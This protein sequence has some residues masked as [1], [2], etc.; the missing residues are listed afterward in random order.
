MKTTISGRA[1]KNLIEYPCLMVDKQDKDLIILAAETQ[2][3]HIRTT[4]LSG[5]IGESFLYTKEEI[6]EIFEVFTGKITIEND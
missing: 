3:L 6:E 1:N 4:T 2:G 5:N